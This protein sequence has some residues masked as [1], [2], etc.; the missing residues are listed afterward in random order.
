[1]K[2]DSHLPTVKRLSR[3]LVISL[4]STT[5]TIPTNLLA[6][7]WEPQGP[8][9]WGGLSTGNILPTFTKAGITYVGFTG[10]FDATCARVRSTNAVLSGTNFTQS[11]VYEKHV[12]EGVICPLVLTP[13]EYRKVEPLGALPA[14]DYK[15]TWKSFSGAPAVTNTFAEFTFTVPPQTEPL[16]RLIQDP[17]L[18][19]AV[20]AAPLARYVLET[21][22]NLT[23]WTSV[24]TNVAPSLTNSATDL[25]L[26]MF[27]YQNQTEVPFNELK[28]PLSFDTPGSSH[29]YRVQVLT[30]ESATPRPLLLTN[31][32]F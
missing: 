8:P 13:S 5:A 19:I 21:S 11:F 20:T 18:A 16:I 10:T 2:T 3:L 26:P 7:S 27:Y 9:T 29:F 12:G 25:V 32:G 1:M 31:P 4:V 22:T 24:A 14:G 28:F 17:V 15:M 6:D 23:A 30:G